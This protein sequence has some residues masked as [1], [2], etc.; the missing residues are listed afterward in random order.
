MKTKILTPVLAVLMVWGM[1][2]VIVAQEK[3]ATP[4]SEDQQAAM[5]EAWNAYKAPGEMHKMLAMDEGEW[6]AEITHWADPSAP[7]EK[8]KGTEVCK[9]VMGGRYLKTSFTSEIMGQPFKGLG[10]TGYDNAK[11]EFIST[12]IDDMGTGMMIARGPAPEG[13]SN[14][15]EMKGTMVDP[16]TGEDMKVREVL[17]RIDENTRMMEMYIEHQGQEMKTM[18]IKYSRK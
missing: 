11:K 6:N 14:T 8:A 10:Y 5:M 7:P 12:W 4:V 16:M 2:T 1:Q 18:E 17:T 3:E 13:D 15:M 9:M